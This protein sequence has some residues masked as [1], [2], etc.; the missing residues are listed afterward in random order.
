MRSSH[1]DVIVVGAGPAGLTAARDLRDREYS[2]LVLEAR[3]RLGGRTHTRALRGYDDTLIEVG[4]QYVHPSLQHNLGKEVRRYDQPVAVEGGDPESVG[5]HIDGQLQRMPVPAHQL[6]ALERALLAM[7]A[8]ARRISTHVPL[9]DQA[10]SDL[11]ISTEAFLEP[12]RLPDQTRQAIFGGLAAIAQCDVRQIS[13]LQWL[14][15]IAGLG[16]PVSLFYGVTEEQLK[17]GTGALWQ[18][19]AEDADADLH[20]GAEVTHVTQDSAGVHVSTASGERHSSTVG[21]IA[22]GAQVL[23][24]ITFAPDLDTERR[25]LLES[26]YV[27]HGFKSFLVVED[28]P[29]AFLG[30]SATPQADSRAPRID[31]LYHDRTLP[32]GRALMVAWGRGQPLADVPDAQAAVTEYLPGA[33]VV[34]LDGHD[35]SADPYARGIN[36]FRRPGEMLR[37]PHTVGRAHGTVLFAAGDLTP[38]IWNGW[39][40][41]A[42]DSGRITAE[43]A[44]ARLRSAGRR[45]AHRSSHTAQHGPHPTPTTEA[46]HV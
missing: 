22:V 39:I 6:V 14:T 27:A 25:E 45:P 9:A 17:D 43:R 31:W 32:D 37:F 21:I 10:L 36:H 20:H 38:G 11:D 19:M 42:L 5:F 24:R 13:M 35:W 2:V 26:T 40:E 33:R 28:A 16:S 41:G 8:A 30:M 34:A 18:A 12:L 44:A 1:H 23:D 7:N 29:T 3:D 46:T 4:G 15:W